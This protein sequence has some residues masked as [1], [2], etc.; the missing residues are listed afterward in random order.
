MSFDKKSLPLSGN[1]M[2][3]S[4]NKMFYRFV[5]NLS[6]PVNIKRFMAGDNNAM[7]TAISYAFGS[8]KKLL[9]DEREPYVP[10]IAS[11]IFAKE[12]FESFG[13]EVDRVEEFDKIKSAPINV[14][15]AA[16]KM[17]AEQSFPE[18]FKNVDSR[19]EY[20]GQQGE[21]DHAANVEKEKEY[22]SSRGP[23]GRPRYN[24]DEYDSER[25]DALE[26]M[27]NTEEYD[28]FEP[29]NFYGASAKAYLKGG[30][31]S[32]FA[33]GKD[34]L[35]DMLS[36]G[37]KKVLKEEYGESDRVASLKVTAAQKGS[38]SNENPKV[39]AH[40]VETLIKCAETLEQLGHPLIKDVDSVLDYVEAELNSFGKKKEKK[41]KKEKKW[42]NP[43]AVCTKSVGRDDE[44]K[45]ERCV[46]NV[47]RQQG[48]KAS[49]S[50]QEFIKQ[51]AFNPAEEDFLSK[52]DDP[53]FD[54]GSSMYEGE[55]DTEDLNKMH[56]TTPAK[57]D[58]N[59]KFEL[60]QLLQKNYSL[61]TTV[62]NKVEELNEKSQTFGRHDQ[63]AKLYFLKI[64]KRRV[65]PKLETVIQEQIDDLS[66]MGVPLDKIYSKMKEG[67]LIDWREDPREFTKEELLSDMMMGV[68]DGFSEHK[69][70][71][72]PERLQSYLADVEKELTDML[73]PATTLYSEN[74]GTLDKVV[75]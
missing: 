13:L 41:E 50:E 60:E 12:L 38:E 74:Y 14:L 15:H 54:L 26:E 59:S 18:M 35:A 36:E 57:F 52:L 40:V 75:E 55:L 3:N 20:F 64:L 31:F 71:M 68:E 28:L 10:Y 25:A 39:F 27:K 23:Q 56:E 62:N 45:F 29:D 61:L 4:E 48:I 19:E 17:N 44:E 67:A 43:W 46:L 72:S 30:N 7:K 53:N 11:L 42:Q 2:R 5:Q 33:K 8:I 47:K 21:L 1:E 37:M 22:L 16:K 69:N 24:Q 73:S 63:E 6:S 58:P 32:K 65:A 34:D 70:S 9:G 51:A 49:L 66:S